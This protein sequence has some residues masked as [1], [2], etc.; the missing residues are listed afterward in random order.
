MSADYI[1]SAQYKCS[2]ACILEDE[3]A[4]KQA[5]WKQYPVLKAATGEYGYEIM[6][7]VMCNLHFALKCFEYYVEVHEK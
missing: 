3:R 7:G 4:V 1:S 2:P 5:V 6:V